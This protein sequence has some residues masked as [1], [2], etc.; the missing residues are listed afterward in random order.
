MRTILVLGGYGFFGGRICAALSKHPGVR[1]LVGGRNGDLARNAALSFGLAP[2]AGVELAATGPAL[3]HRFTELR[4]NTVVHTAGPFQGQDYT[5]ALA[6]IDAGCHYADLGDGRQFV[7]GIERLDAAARAKGLRIISGASSVPGLSSAVVE[8]FRPQFTQMTS[9]RLGISSGARAP[10][11]ATV[12]GIFGYCG[13][14]FQR[15]E[16]GTWVTT[17]GWMDLTRYQF[18]NP[19]GSRWLGS[20]D[21]PDLELFP[22]RYSAKTVTFHAGF[23]SDPGHLVVWGIAGLVKAELLSSASGFAKPLNRLSR[24]LEP[25]VSDQGGMFVKIDGVDHDGREKTVSWHL[26]AANNHGPYIPCG[27]SIALAKKLANGGEGLPVGAMPC[28][29]LLTVEEYLAPLR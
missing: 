11:L 26:L 27:A 3:A 2:E 23:A 25:I 24:W 6:A 16:G 12:Q 19:L 15:L 4:V 8:R 21:I 9:I 17:Y 5:V 20:C 7:C 10:G 29:G 1:V 18:P 14:P 13:K 28:V 22:E